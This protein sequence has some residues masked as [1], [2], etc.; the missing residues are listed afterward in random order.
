MQAESRWFTIIGKEKHEWPQLYL[1]MAGVPQIIAALSCW[2]RGV[3]RCGPFGRAVPQ[4]ELS[5]ENDGS[6]GWEEETAIWFG[7][8]E[9]FCR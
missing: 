8:E 5:G 6:T 7:R 9:V 2:G 4:R 1:Y 3:P